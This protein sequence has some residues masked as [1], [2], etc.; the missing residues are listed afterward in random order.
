MSPWRTGFVAP[1]SHTVGLSPKLVASLIT[2]ILLYVVSQ[3]TT[4]DRE[5]EQAVNVLG[6]LLATYIAGPGTVESDQTEPPNLGGP[7]N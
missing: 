3:I 5:V 1:P 7:V 6:M 2:G 4:I